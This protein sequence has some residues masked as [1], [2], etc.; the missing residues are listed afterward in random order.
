MWDKVHP[1]RPKIGEM[2]QEEPAESDEWWY[3]LI[4]MTDK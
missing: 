4:V 2:R 1:G 3:K